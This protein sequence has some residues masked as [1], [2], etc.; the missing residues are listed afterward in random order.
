MSQPTSYYNENQ[1]GGPYSSM[2]GRAPGSGGVPGGTANRPQQQNPFSYSSGV[3]SGSSGGLRSMQQQQPQQPPQQQPH[4]QQQFNQ[5]KQGAEQNVPSTSF[6]SSG[7]NGNF[8]MAENGAFK[9]QQQQQQQ[10]QQPELPN[11]W[12]PAAAATVMSAATKGGLTQDAMF[13]F[14][15][16]AGRTFIARGTA[17]FI[18]GLERFMTSLRVFFQVDNRY[19]QRKLRTILFPYMKK[20]WRRSVRSLIL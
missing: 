4:Q 8:H 12:N 2:Y 9:Q 11:F 13:D 1:Q 14:A 7:S 20:N 10:P 18:P 19:V 6:R 5:P 17:R 3:N 15:S 16:S